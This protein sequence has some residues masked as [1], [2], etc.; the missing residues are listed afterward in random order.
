ML[1]V[2]TCV[3]FLVRIDEGPAPVQRF[4][5]TYS[6][7]DPG[8]RHRLLVLRRG[9]RTEAQWLPFASG[10]D[11]HNVAYDLLDVEDAGYDLGAYREVLRPRAR[12]TSAS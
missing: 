2:D 10:L 4:A 6:E 7:N 12:T 9:F 11:H 3:A 1:A 5:E 8:L